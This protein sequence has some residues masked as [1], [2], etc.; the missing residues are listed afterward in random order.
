LVAA[1]EL[2][3]DPELDPAEMDGPLIDPAEVGLVRAVR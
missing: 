1:P 2:V 3:A